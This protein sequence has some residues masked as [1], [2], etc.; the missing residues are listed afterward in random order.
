[1]SSMEPTHLRRGSLLTRHTR[2]VR[3]VA[4]AAIL[5]TFAPAARADVVTLTPVKDNTLYQDVLGSL[6]NGAGVNLFAGKTTTG[7]LR[8]AV[9]D[10]DVARAVHPGAIVQSVTLRMHVSRTISGPETSTLHRVLVEWGEGT[11]NSS[12]DPQGG[13][14]GAPAT[15]GDATWLHTFYSTQSWTAQGGDFSATVSATANPDTVDFYQWGST[16]QMVAD[17]QAWTDNPAADHGWLLR[18]NETPLSTAKRFDSREASDPALRPQLTIVFQR[19]PTD[20]VP[21]A[22]HVQ[23]EPAFPNPFNPTTTLAY[24]L[25]A[26]GAVRLELLDVRGTLVTSLVSGDESAGR[27]VVIWDGRD[28]GGARVASGVYVVRLAAGATL[29]STRVVLLK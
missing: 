4:V 22:I 6:S 2:Q 27:H 11:S 8:R 1:M 23:L 18:V 3:S 17:V 29:Q 25:P 12:N 14:A 15:T 24:V 10:F 9:L 28:A 16:A 7:R 26:P 5:C 21:V 19:A 13:G 20:V